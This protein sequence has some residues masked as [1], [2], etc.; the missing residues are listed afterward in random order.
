M[1]DSMIETVPVL[2]GAAAHPER[3]WVYA[4][5]VALVLVFLALDLGVFHRRAREVSAREAGAWSVVW[6]MCALSFSVLV[7]YAYSAHWLGLGLDVPIVG[8]PGATATVDGATAVKQYLAGYLVEWSLSV[9]NLFVIAVI[10]A[11]FKVPAA[12]QHRVLFW[13]IIGA[14]IMRG[15]MIALGALL[16]QRFGWIT[17]VFG[18][19]LMLTAARMA[20]SG[21]EGVDPERNVLV[22]AVRRVWPVSTEYDGQRFFTM[23]P[24][25]EATG[26]GAG[27]MARGRRA[28]TPL[29]LALLV[30][31]F[32][33]VV[34][35]VDSVPA[36]FSIT[37]DAFI[38][39]SSN[40]FAILGLRSL[41]FVLAS[42]LGRFRFLKPALVLILLFVGAKMLLVHSEYKVDTAVSLGVILGLL[43]AGVGA[44]LVLPPRE[45][46]PAG[47][48]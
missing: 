21:E 40:V 23:L 45:K 25:P 38:V 35:A 26:A 34:F 47:E 6:T 43:A 33:D 8:S 9:D 2:L 13:G 1:L 41:Y 10:F 27:G 5:F 48:A 14:L 12:Y 19:F 7:Y 24:G 42:M 29:L 39:F 28:V 17:Y 37:G 46:P 32:T 11:Y 30:V 22:R 36:I 31:E 44:S 15:G 18:G 3:V 16:I 4:A 20:M